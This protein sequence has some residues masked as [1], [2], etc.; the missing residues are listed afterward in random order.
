[1]ATSLNKYIKSTSLSLS[2][3]MASFTDDEIP[4]ISLVGIDNDAATVGGGRRAEVKKK[5]TK[6]CEVW[7]IFQVVDH[8]VDPSLFPK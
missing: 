4:V 6:A 7:G 8:S 1:M 5:I 3:A 2:V